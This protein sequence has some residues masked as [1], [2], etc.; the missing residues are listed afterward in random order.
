MWGTNSYLP[1]GTGNR[2]KA[3]SPSPA[4]CSGCNCTPWLWYP[5]TARRR[6]VYIFLSATYVPP[7]GNLFMLREQPECYCASDDKQATE[8]G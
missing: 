7:N 5:D 8:P 2:S 3:V 1:L 6:S 4:D